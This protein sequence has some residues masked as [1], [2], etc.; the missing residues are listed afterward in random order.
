MRKKENEKE[1]K[2]ITKL[3]QTIPNQTNGWIE[4]KAVENTECGLVKERQIERK[5]MNVKLVLSWSIIQNVT[6]WVWNVDRS[7][8]LCI[9]C[10]CVC[11]VVVVMVCGCL[12]FAWRFSLLFTINY[13][14]MKILCVWIFYQMFQRKKTSEPTKKHMEKYDSGLLQRFLCTVLT[15]KFIYEL[16]F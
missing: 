1:T 2:M 4:R 16:L 8:F 15:L 6:M 11:E 9:L 10:V 3:N 12:L 13:F 5:N 14:T 7:C